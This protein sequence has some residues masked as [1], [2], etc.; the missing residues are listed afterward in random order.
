MKNFLQSILIVLIMFIVFVAM[1]L[2]IGCSTEN[3]LCSDNYCVSGEIF[4]RSE[5][6]EDEEFSEVDIV[7]YEVLRAF[8]NTAPQTP[9]ETTPAPVETGVSLMDIIADVGAGNETYL[10]KTVTVAGTVAFKTDDGTA[11][12]IYKNASAIQAAKEKAVFNIISLDD[13]VPL[14]NYTVGDTYTFAVFV[15]LILPPNQDRV[16]YSIGATLAK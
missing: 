14:A 7:E 6:F 13:P 3:P 1:M 10:N 12:I 8:A 9:V 4:L 2:S 5:L 16:F 15:A 11:I